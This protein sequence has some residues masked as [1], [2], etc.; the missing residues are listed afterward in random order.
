LLFLLR[1]ST[2][3][4]AFTPSS[5]GLLCMCL[6]TSLSLLP[7]SLVSYNSGNPVFSFSW[8]PFYSVDFLFPCFHFHKHVLRYNSMI[9]WCMNLAKIK[10]QT[11]EMRFFISI[12]EA[13]S[14]RAAAVDADFPGKLIRI[15]FLIRKLPQMKL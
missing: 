11:S 15:T 8:K 3:F 13:S 14:H 5:S 6:G 10:L 2:Y 4:R 1:C 7:I 9:C 12:A